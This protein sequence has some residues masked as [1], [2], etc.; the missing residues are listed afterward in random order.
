MLMKRRKRIKKIFGFIP[1]DDN[2]WKLNESR[3]D[4]LRAQTDAFRIGFDIFKPI[5]LFGGVFIIVSYIFTKGI[6]IINSLT[7][8]GWTFVGLI[9][10]IIWV[11]R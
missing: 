5:I 10:Y 4:L 9:L 8:M 7:L 6:E 11:R 2:Q 3:S 1:I